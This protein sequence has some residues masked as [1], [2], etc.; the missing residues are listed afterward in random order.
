MKKVLILLI[1][2]ILFCGC[3][4]NK[5][6]INCNNYKEEVKN[7]AILIDVRTISEYEEYHLSDAVSLP[8]SDINNISNIVD[9]KEK[10]IIVYCQSGNRSKQ[11]YNIL[12]KMGYK[13]VL[14]LGGLN[15]C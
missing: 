2:I 13:N 14:D 12:K 4:D 11:A 7:G 1:G 10:E 5:K 15:N 3:N 9:N 8:L 6:E